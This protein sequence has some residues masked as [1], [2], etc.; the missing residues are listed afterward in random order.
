MGETYRQANYKGNVINTA[1][2]ACTWDKNLLIRQLRIEKK[3]VQLDRPRFKFQLYHLV[4]CF[5][6]LICEMGSMASLL[7]L[8]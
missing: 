3:T 6:Q 5:R 1:I 7:F 2:K 8:Y 4:E